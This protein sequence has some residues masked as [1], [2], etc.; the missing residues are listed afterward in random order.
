[1]SCPVILRDTFR[2]IAGTS[3]LLQL[4]HKSSGDSA[5]RKILPILA[6]MLSHE[7]SVWESHPG[8]ENTFP[9]CHA[10]VC[11]S[12]GICRAKA[13]YRAHQIVFIQLVDMNFKCCFK[14]NSRVEH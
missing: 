13:Q 1:M 12:N 8:N 11:T 9:M 10:S 14:I 2:P 3:C 5:K 7:K 4:P 6:E